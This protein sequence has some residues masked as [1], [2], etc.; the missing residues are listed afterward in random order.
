MDVTYT[1]ISLELMQDTWSGYRLTFPHRIASM[2]QSLRHE[3]QLQPV[4]VRSHEGQYQ[5]I[6]GFKRYYASQSLGWPSLKA[7]VLGTDEVTA[8][9]IIIRC[10]SKNV[11]LHDY[12]EALVIR[13]LYK[14]H[15]LGQEKIS[16]LLGRSVSW[17]SRRLSY[18]GRLS[19]Q[20][21]SQLQLGTITVS[22]ARELVNLPRG[23]QD[24]ILQLISGHGF[25]TRQ[26]AQLVKCYMQGSQQ[27]QA[28]LM[29]N[30]R[31]AINSYSENKGH[32]SR[33]GLHG[34]RL[35]RTVRLLEHQQHVMIGQS[36]NPPLSSLPVNERAILSEHFGAV[37]KKAQIIQSILKDYR[38]ER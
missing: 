30:P 17:V 4:V 33:L 12:E 29:E 2:G 24:E 38:D 19:E 23:K 37:L 34:N 8:K 13:S 11:P 28:Y 20:V 7:L 1:D 26:T 15:L 18:I 35:L 36:T 32:D 25:S 9:C 14:D 5:L 22:H 27:E 3:G 6:D 31:Q 16:K 10:N 21:Q